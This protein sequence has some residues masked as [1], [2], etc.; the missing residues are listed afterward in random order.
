V[1]EGDT[2]RVL[3]VMR[4]NHLGKNAEIIGEV[5]ENPKKWYS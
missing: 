2:E 4:K 3:D 5:K 1:P